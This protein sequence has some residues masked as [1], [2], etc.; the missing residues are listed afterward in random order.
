MSFTK[1]YFLLL[2]GFWAGAVS[3]RAAELTAAEVETLQAAPQGGVVLLRELCAR[4]RDL[5]TLPVA[6]ADAHGP[7]FLFSDKPEYFYA[8]NGIALE[9]DVKPGVVRLYLYH[10]PEPGAGP[11]TIS[12]VI[13]NLGRKTMKLRFLRYAF[14]APG[15]NYQK[16]GKTGLIDYFNSK[17]EKTG[18]RIPP[19]AR[20]V[21]DPRLDATT[22]T[23]DE[24]AHGF[25]EFEINQPARVT[26]FQRDP[27]Q[28]SVAVVDTLPKLLREI[29]GRPATGSGSGLFLA[30]DF[31]VTAQNGFVLDTTGGPMRLLLADGKRDPYIVGH[32]SID[33][34][35]SVRDRGN[36]GVMYR[37]RLK[38]RSGDGRG[39]ALLMTRSGGTNVYCGAQAGA[40]RVNR[41]VW[42]G[43]TVAIPT[44]RV[45][46]GSPGE[47][48]VIQK[49][50]PPPKGRTGEIEITYSPPGASCLPTPMLLAPY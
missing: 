50:P 7:Q 18:R 8:G 24:L 45:S 13:R 19:G 46:Y 3:A 23:T 9:E 49:F 39:L 41:G 32:D 11:K 30:S 48:V 37:I 28:S 20:A 15:K 40:V 27:G 29:S 43:G 5:P 17:P 21:L 44:G 2:A 35:D 25:Y 38:W 14:P 31:N 16:I 6:I 36:Y 26:V 1:L 42:P 47:M 33:Q 12:A 4:Q 34:L 10:V 22:V